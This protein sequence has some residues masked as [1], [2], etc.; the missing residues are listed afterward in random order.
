MST[1]AGLFDLIFEMEKGLD[2]TDNLMRTIVCEKMA[3]NT[4]LKKGRKRCQFKISLPCEV[5]TFTDKANDIVSE[6]GNE[7]EN[8]IIDHLFDLINEMQKES[9]RLDNGIKELIYEEYLAE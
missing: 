4:G 9:E 8:I 1:I 7:N 6:I 5:K 3:L 2:R